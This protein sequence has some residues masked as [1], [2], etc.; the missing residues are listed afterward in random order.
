MAG[1]SVCSTALA[2]LAIVRHAAVPPQPTCYLWRMYAERIGGTRFV[3][4]E[5]ED[6]AG[7]ELQARIHA[8]ARATATKAL[9][10]A[11]ALT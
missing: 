2:A 10:D 3:A 5:R 8:R 11:H 6:V 1:W 7:T 9:F 4:D